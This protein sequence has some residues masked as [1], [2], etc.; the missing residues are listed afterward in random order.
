MSRRLLY[1]GIVCAA[2]G[3]SATTFAQQTPAGGGAP[4]TPKQLIIRFFGFQG[5]REERA[6]QT[7]TVD[8]IQHNPRF[9]RMDEFTGAKGNQAWVK[10]GEEANR[11]GIQLVA[12][13]G[14]GLRNP[15]ILIGEG[16]L[17]H[18]VYRGN[19]PDPDA[20]GQTYEAFAFESFRVRG[21]KFSEHWDQVRLAPGWMTPP[22]RPA[23]APAGNRGAAPAGRGQAAAP[24]P[25]PSAGCTA[26]PATLAANKQLVTS[27]FEQPNAAR[28]G[29][30]LAEDYV[31]H[32]PRFAKFNREN[33]VRGRDGYVKAVEKG[34]AVPI[35]PQPRTRDHVVAECDYA[36][37]VWKQVL[38]DPDTPSRTWEAFT[39]DA[40]RVRDG[41]L[42]EH[43]DHDQK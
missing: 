24:P 39:F 11:R 6:A 42:A 17:V 13:N 29:A 28:R 22:P 1:I 8:Y 31:D 36:S 10:A 16:D 4:E 38:P 5:T 12:L 30:L 41:K 20:P 15:I 33:N 19:S 43:W 3:G 23:A 21:D 9:L 37:V 32:S 25:E 35:P 18:A 7:Q 27:Y 40:F 34:I 14:V 26:T 2:L